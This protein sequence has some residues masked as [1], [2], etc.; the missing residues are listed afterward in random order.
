V[1][2]LQP[3]MSMKAPALV[4]ASPAL[5]WLNDSQP[6]DHYPLAVLS[7]HY[8]L[9]HSVLLCHVLCI[10]WCNRQVQIEPTPYPTPWT[11]R[12]QVHEFTYDV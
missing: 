8:A 11:A 9:N 4:I 10:N 5:I 12:Q 6:R 2:E 3:G 7:D 1:L